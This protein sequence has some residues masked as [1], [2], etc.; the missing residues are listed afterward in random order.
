MQYQRLNPRAVDE[1]RQFAEGIVFRLN[2]ALAKPSEM[3]P[4]RGSTAHGWQSRARRSVDHSPAMASAGP[5]V[6][7]QA[8]YGKRRQPP[9]NAGPGVCGNCQGDEALEEC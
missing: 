9:I 3:V 5:L 8:L 2:F 7:L 6:R 1:K 4:E